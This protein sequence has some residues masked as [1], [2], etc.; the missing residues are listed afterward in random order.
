MSQKTNVYPRIHIENEDK[1]LYCGTA[2][3]MN[4]SPSSKYRITYHYI[5]VAVG[6]Q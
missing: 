5:K 4:N 2:F 1:D 3:I 6:I